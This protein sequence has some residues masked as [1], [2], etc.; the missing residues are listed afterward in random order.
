M[1]SCR[2]KEKCEE[3]PEIENGEPSREKVI[4]RKGGGKTC[5]IPRDIAQARQG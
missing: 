4:K 1:K 5:G 2:G 3:M